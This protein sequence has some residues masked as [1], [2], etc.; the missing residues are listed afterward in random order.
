MVLL[1]TVCQHTT[2]FSNTHTSLYLTQKGDL[3]H[4]PQI[5]MWGKIKFLG[6][7]LSIY[8]QF[9]YFSFSFIEW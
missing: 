3:L 4:M 6:R 9:L 8:V 7:F 5:G 1:L 2:S